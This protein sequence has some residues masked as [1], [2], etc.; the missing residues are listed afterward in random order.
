MRPA[1]RPGDGLLAIC[2][3][4]TLGRANCG[5]FATRHCPRAGSS[6]A[7]VTSRL[8]SQRD[9]RGSLRQ[10]ATHRAS[11][12]RAQFGSVSAAGSYRVV[13]TG[14]RTQSRPLA[15]RVLLRARHCWL[16]LSGSTQWSVG[17]WPNNHRVLGRGGEM[18]TGSGRAIEIAPFHSRGSL[19][20][21][22]VSGRWP[23]STK[24]WAQVLRV[25]VRVASLPGLLSTTTIFGARE[26]LP[27]FSGARHC[28]TGSR[29]GHRRW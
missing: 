10:P 4:A 9:V 29:R 21:F 20:G 6:S 22:V 28:R 19:K 26:E 25:A 7:S 5:C 3:A 18:E 16:M 8:G 24:E 12:T 15:A 14:A 17:R 2:A 11:S 23:D 13:W 1:L 27:G